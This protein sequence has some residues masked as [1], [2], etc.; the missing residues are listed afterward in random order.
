MF[1]DEPY[2]MNYLAYS[3]VE[4][5]KNINKALAMLRKANNL[6]KN[7]GY[8]T[9]SLGGALYKLN[10]FSE[11]KIH[12]RQAI[13]LMPSDPVVNDHFADCLWMNNEKIQARYY[14]NYVLNLESAEEKLKKQI[15]QKLLFGLEKI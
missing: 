1:P 6:K 15:K 10:N 4:K 9:D 13:I 11:A 3:W 2:V 8:I 7:D 5:G 14:W 12:L